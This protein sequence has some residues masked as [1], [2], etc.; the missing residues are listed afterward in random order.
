VK[1]DTLTKKISFAEVEAA[2]LQG[3]NEQRAQEA[4]RQNSSTEKWYVDRRVA[5]GDYV[6][7]ILTD[8]EDLWCRHDEVD[9]TVDGVGHFNVV[10]EEGGEGQGEDAHFVIK[11]IPEGAKSSDDWRYFRKNGS[12]AS[13]CGYDWDGDWWECGAV[14]RM[15]VFYE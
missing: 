15:V 8:I 12:Y 6:P 7:H 13:H 9:F 3:L 14:E 11:F 10:D 5:N 1:E 4:D 2:L